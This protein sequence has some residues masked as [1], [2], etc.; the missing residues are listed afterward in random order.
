MNLGRDGQ[1]LAKSVWYT[2][3][4]FRYTLIPERGEGYA[5]DGEE[6]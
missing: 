4:E 2:H 3:W 6:Q 1:G 5:R